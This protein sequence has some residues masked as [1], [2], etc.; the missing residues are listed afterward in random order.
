MT[1]TATSN[2]VLNYYSNNWERI[3][4]CYDL[5]DRGLPVDPAWY[6][7]RLYNQFLE[8]HKPKSVLDIGCGGGWTTLDSLKL[9]VKTI[10]LEPVIELKDFAENLL[11]KEGFDGKNILNEDLLY[12][13]TLENNSQDCIALLSVIPHVPLNKIEKIHKELYRVLKPGGKLVIAYRNELFDLFTFNSITLEFYKNRIW[14]LDELKK[15]SETPEVLKA[16]SGLINNP[17]LPGKFHTNAKDK[18]FGKLN[19]FKTNPLTI[20]EYLSSYGLKW[21]ESHFY[22]FHAVPP[23]ISNEVQDL[24]KI[25]HHL[26][27]NYSSDWR[28]NFMCPMYLVIS[29]K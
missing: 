10:G 19:R 18:S 8:K 3:A 13:K 22:H 17:D 14:E 11:Q 2:D 21:L 4:N 6:R 5:D 26:E 24:K 28:A 25:N 15:L 29:E 1:K 9:G 27:L 16:L 20:K 7:R 12:I 23:L